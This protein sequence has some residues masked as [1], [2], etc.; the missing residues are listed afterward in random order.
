MLTIT[1]G[2]RVGSDAKVTANGACFFSLAH[3]EKGYTKQDGTQ[4]ADT[5]VWVNV[6][7]AKG[8]KLAPYIKKGAYI[9]ASANGINSQIHEGKVNLSI[10]ANIIE[11]GGASVNSDQPS[12]PA[13]TPEAGDDLPF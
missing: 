6:F 4:V 13:P 2:G 9:I 8:E 1:V 7:K 3:T 12:A 5:T 10:N 11:F